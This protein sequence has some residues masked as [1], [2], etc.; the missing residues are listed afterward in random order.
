[1]GRLDSL[2]LLVRLLDASKGGS[3]RPLAAAEALSIFEP[4]QTRYEIKSQKRCKRG[5]KIRWSMGLQDVDDKTAARVYVEVGGTKDGPNLL[6]NALKGYV[7][8]AAC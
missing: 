8:V 2:S 5:G 6:D 7:I 1:M 3:S 4:R